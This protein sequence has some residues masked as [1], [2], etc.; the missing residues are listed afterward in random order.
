MRATAKTSQLQ[1]RVSPAQKAAIQREA[2][3]AGMDLSAFV[4]HRLL[5]VAATRFQVLTAACVEE[6]GLRFALAELNSFLAGLGAGEL[7]DA[8]A[9]RPQRAL[10]PIQANY[11]AAMVECACARSRIAPP[12]WTGE[13]A[14]LSEPLFGSELQSL[15]LYLLTH[16][17][18][19]FRRRNI[20]IDASIGAQV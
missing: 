7:R 5:P 4:L 10:A 3:Q 13:I 20:F 6:S 9:S 2:R 12:A 19:A 18:P 11:I 14:P 17:P 8:V 15:R 1:I 16:S